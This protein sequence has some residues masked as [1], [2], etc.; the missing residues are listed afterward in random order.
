MAVGRVA[1]VGEATLEAAGFR[2]V[3]VVVEA[4]GF[5]LDEGA[6]VVLDKVEVRRAAVPKVEDRR[7]SSSDTEG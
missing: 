6:D 3:V 5:G 1:E 7:L 2:A 4:V